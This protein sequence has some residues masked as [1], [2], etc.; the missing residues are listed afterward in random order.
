MMHDDKPKP[1]ALIVQIFDHDNH[2]KTIISKDG[3]TLTLTDP[4]LNEITALRK[5]FDS[6]RDEDRVM[7]DGAT[8]YLR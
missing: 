2:V 8:F 4:M 7:L 6:I 3:N 1:D 5:R